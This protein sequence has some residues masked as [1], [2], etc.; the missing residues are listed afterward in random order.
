MIY[1]N[2]VLKR[3]GKIEKYLGVRALR[4]QHGEST[5]TVSAYPGSK[6]RKRFT[7]VEALLNNPKGYFLQV[8]GEGLASKVGKAFG[9]QDVQVNNDEFD[10]KYI[11]KSNDEFFATQILT[12]RVQDGLLAL[13][14]HHPFVELD[15]NKLVMELSSYLKNEEDYDL[16]ID[17]SLLI[18]DRIKEL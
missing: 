5:V 18:I 11:I 13:R 2:E 15:N 9:S 1:E 3:N 10:N 14:K 8:Y 7:M 12:P 4:F 17:T 6:H 16:L